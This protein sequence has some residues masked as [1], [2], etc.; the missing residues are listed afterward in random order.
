MTFWRKLLGRQGEQMAQAYLKK[1][2]YKIVEQNI[3]SRLGE[4]DIVALD[5]EVL[6]FCEVRSRKGGTLYQAAESIGVK[7]QQRL[8]RLAEAYLQTKPHLLER[9][10]RFD[11]VV[12]NKNREY[13]Q[14]ELI[15]DAFRPGW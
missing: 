6:V 11:V 2:G 14:I 5:G 4:L 10:C 9:E 13:W 15:K 3:Q 1:N 12:L 8:L 7:K